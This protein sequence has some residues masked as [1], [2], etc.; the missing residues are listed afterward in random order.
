[1]NLSIRH[2]LLQ[3]GATISTENLGVKNLISEIESTIKMHGGNATEDNIFLHLLSKQKVIG[4]TKRIIQVKR[5]GTFVLITFMNGSFGVQVLQF[6]VRVYCNGRYMSVNE[7]EQY[8]KP[9]ADV[10]KLIQ[11]KMKGN[12]FFKLKPSQR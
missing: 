1:M 10:D 8:S 9:R 7:Y 3:N 4:S 2:Q 11:N 12:E 5:K 6:Q